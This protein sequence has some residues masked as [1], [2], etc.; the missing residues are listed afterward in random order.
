MKKFTALV[1]GLTAVFALTA[2]NSKGKEVKAE[3]FKEKSAKVEDHQYSEATIKYSYSNEYEVPNFG[4]MFGDLLGDEA[5]SLEGE[6]GPSKESGKGEAKFTFKDG[7]WTTE[8]KELSEDI[9]D[10][11]GISFKDADFDME[12]LTTQY[13]SMAQQYGIKSTLK[14]YVDPFGVEVT[15]K[16]DINDEET[17]STGKLDVYEYVSFDKY[18]FLNKLNVKVNINSTV[19]VGEKD[20]TT[21]IISNIDATIS[22]K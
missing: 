13:E 5:E 11:V 10:L 19:K 22:Y 6:T 3:E 4:E 21:K 17:K 12:E 2:C 16:G 7:E 14:F 9:I 8:E 20:Y 15:A 1:M 18:G